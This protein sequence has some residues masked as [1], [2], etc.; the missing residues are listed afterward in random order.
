[1]NR[2]DEFIDVYNS[3]DNLL[4]DKYNAPSRAFSCIKRYEDE[5]KDSDYESVRERGFNLEKI[6]MIRNT[7]IHD[8][9]INNE[10]AFEV[11]SKIIDFIKREMKL[12]NFPKTMLDIS[13]KFDSIY[14]IS[15]SDKVRN[16]IN[17]MA[18]R[19]ISHAP[20]VD[21][22]NRLIGVFS[23]STFFTFILNEN[24]INI[25]D[26]LLIQ[27]FLEYTKLE[28]HNSESY[29][30]VKKNAFAID[31]EKKIL[32]KDQNNKRIVMFFITRNGKEDEPILGIVTAI[33]FKRLFEN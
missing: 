32:K 22:N 19:K 7:L 6:R 13:T 9:K 25:S 12:I 11:N 31:Y 20:I 33:D 21:S 14:K 27:D 30:F 5:L 15:L 1:M 3:L 17:I 18:G 16:V 29:M 8:A 28:K 4:R 24:M 26:E 2:N 10:D 23:E